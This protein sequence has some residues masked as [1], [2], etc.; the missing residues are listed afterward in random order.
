[1]SNLD[2]LRREM[3]S[4]GMT[5]F[6]VSDIDS[7]AWVTGFTGSSGQVVVAADGGRFISDS[8]YTIQAAEQVKGL[9]IFTADSKVERMTFLAEHLSGRASGGMGFDGAKMTLSALKLVSEKRDY[10]EMESCGDPIA[11][12]RLIK[13][14]A[15]IAKMKASCQLADACMKHVSRLIQPGVSEWE[16]GLDIEFFYRRQFAE[17]S[18]EPIVVSGKRSAQVHARASKKLLEA[19]DFVTI[20]CGG[21]LD[22]YCSDITRTF[23]VGK[24]SDRHREI[25][26]QVLKAQMAALDAIKPGALAKDVD[27]LSRQVL[28]EKDLGKYMG[29]GLGHGLGQLV[30]DGGSLSPSSTNTVTEGQIWTVE[31]GVY[32]E[33]FGGVRIEDDVVV[34][35]TGCDLLTHFP[36]E[37]M[38]LPQG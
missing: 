17:L 25:Y 27:S 5:A 29:H 9:E 16:I 6:L 30:H 34:T 19:G 21:K 26:S 4:R 13:S 11:P 35:S 3:A 37:L 38:E 2:R 33:G 7:V 20:D 22:G 10:I 18:F 28:D 8:R 1:M 24:A 31:P 15:E 32:I 36:K 23:V 12:L 14:A